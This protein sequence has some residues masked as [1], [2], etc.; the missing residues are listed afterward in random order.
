VKNA[1]PENLPAKA[2][3][4]TVVQGDTLYGI[5]VK[6]FGTPRYYERIFEENRDRIS[7]PNTLQIGLNLKMPDVPSKTGGAGSGVKG[8]E[9]GPVPAASPL[10]AGDSGSKDLR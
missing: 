5:S 3:T 8:R 7:D 1:A 9:P 10:P 4:Y 2:T 6:V